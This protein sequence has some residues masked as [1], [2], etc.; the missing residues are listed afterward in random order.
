[1]PHFL[2]CSAS[3]SCTV[4]RPVSHHIPPEDKLLPVRS[5]PGKVKDD[6]GINVH[7]GNAYLDK[8]AY[9]PPVL[10]NEAQLPGQMPDSPRDAAFNRTTNP[11]EKKGVPLL[12]ETLSCSTNSRLHQ[13]PSGILVNMEQPC[14]AEQPSPAAIAAPS[15]LRI[16]LH[17]Q[18]SSASFSLQYRN[19]EQLLAPNSFIHPLQQHS[20]SARSSDLL[21]SRCSRRHFPVLSSNPESLWHMAEPPFLR[22]FS[23]KSE[24]WRLYRHFQLSYTHPD[25]GQN[26]ALGSGGSLSTAASAFDARAGLTAAAAAATGSA[27]CVSPSAVREA[28]LCQLQRELDVTESLPCCPLLLLPHRVYEQSDAMYV[29]YDS[30]GEYED[31]YTFLRARQRLSEGACR[32]IMRQLLQVRWFQNAGTAD[33]V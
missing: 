4:H 30:E 23:R 9:N 1:M 19:S 6:S 33:S 11:A 3:F 14:P 20:S 13:P 15:K 32:S 28:A 22:C 29:V 5:S 27:G 16:P 21:H 17:L 24:T 2:C 25:S 10:L 7:T 12:E 8:D 18:G 31:L 26:E